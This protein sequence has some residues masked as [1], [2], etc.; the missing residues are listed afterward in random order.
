MPIRSARPTR[1]TRVQGRSDGRPWNHV[2]ERADVYP[3]AVTAIASI[4]VIVA[5]VLTIKALGG[6]DSAN[7]DKEVAERRAKEAEK[8]AQEAQDKVERLQKDLQ[9]MDKKVGMAVDS[10][11]AAQNDADRA[12]AKANLEKLRR[13]KADMEVRIQ[14][15]KDA[16]ALAKR[17]QGAQVSAECQNNPLA[18]G[19][20]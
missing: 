19:C 1:R 5:I 8:L 20:M 6:E 9:D 4:G 13:E 7:K 2:T 18:K 15:A 10:V 14:A 12:S 11:V 17:K 3:D 16:A